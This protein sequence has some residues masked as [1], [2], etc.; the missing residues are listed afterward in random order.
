M[1]N[2]ENFDKVWFTNRDLIKDALKNSDIKDSV[3]QIISKEIIYKDG[4]IVYHDY[5][6]VIDHQQL[7][8]EI[9]NYLEMKNLTITNL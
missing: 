6:L 5:E 9:A 4:E 1:N 8:N 2:T 7:A 3:T